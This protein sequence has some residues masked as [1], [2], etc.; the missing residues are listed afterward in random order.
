MLILWA[1]ARLAFPVDGNEMDRLVTVL[2][3]WQQVWRERATP[4]L[5][6]VACLEDVEVRRACR[7]AA[8]INTE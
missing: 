7:D 8:Q 2:E 4:Y 6:L 3:N 1:T 5:G